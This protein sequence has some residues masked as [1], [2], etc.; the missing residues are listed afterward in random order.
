MWPYASAEEAT[1]QAA[2][3]FVGGS[4]LEIEGL[5]IPF[6]GPV[7]GRKDFHLQDFGPDTD[8]A[9]DWYPHGRPI[10]YDHGMDP[11]MKA[12]VLGRQNEHEI[13]DEGVWARGVLDTSAKFI[14]QVQQ[15]VDKGILF[16]SSGSVPQAMQATKTGHITRW[17]W[18]ELTLT[19]TPSNLLA[20]PRFIKSVEHLQHLA[21]LDLEIPQQLITEALK[22][23]D[24]YEDIGGDDESLPFADD[25]DRVLAG[26]E[27]FRDR[28]VSLVDRRVKSGRVLSAA[29]RERLARHPGS[30]RELADDLDL[31][32]TDADADKATK[33]ALAELANETERIL[34]RSLGVPI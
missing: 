5:A 3:K 2:V 12:S 25:A 23:L 20:Q 30:L 7:G 10:L 9:F 16:F 6:G 27:S 8:F 21:D 22:R 26:I 19:P 4:D 14:K 34:S 33:S 24:S 32:L 28:A 15:L 31:L 18:G 11:A 1:M 13:T 17:P 29:T